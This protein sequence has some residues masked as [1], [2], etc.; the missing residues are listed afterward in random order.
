ME[1]EIKALKRARDWHQ[2]QLDRNNITPLGRIKQETKIEM[3]DDFIRFFENILKK[4]RKR[5][6]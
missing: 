1:E 6:E 3:I 2:L 5:L 4:Q